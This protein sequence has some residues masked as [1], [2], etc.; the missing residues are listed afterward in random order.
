MKRI[1]IFLAVCASF[2]SA[3]TERQPEVSCINGIE[4]ISTYRGGVTHAIDAEGKPVTCD[5]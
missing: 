1:V 4:Y 3:C 2:A 5:E